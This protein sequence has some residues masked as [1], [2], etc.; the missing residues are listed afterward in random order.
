MEMNILAMNSLKN[1]RKV[2]SF[3]ISSSSF[4]VIFE[5]EGILSEKNLK[6]K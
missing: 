2:D 4:T 3:K 6:K 1:K 5:K